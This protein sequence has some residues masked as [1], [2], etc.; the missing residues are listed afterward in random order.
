[1]PTTSFTA[2]TTHATTQVNTT[3][4]G[5]QYGEQ[6]VTLSN[7]SSVIFY[8]SGNQVLARTIGSNGAPS[9]SEIVIA[10][11][12]NGGFD[13]QI[14]ATVLTNG[15]IAVAYCRNNGA[16]TDIVYVIRDSNMNFISSGV[17]TTGV[18]TL[19][20]D[21]AATAGGGFVIAYEKVFS[22]TDHDIAFRRFD[23]AGTSTDPA[24]GVVFDGSGFYDE[25]PSVAVLNDGKIV[26]GY[27]R[28]DTVSGNTGAWQMVANADATQFLAPAQFDGFGTYNTRADV[29]ALSGGG[30]AINY[31]DNG[32]GNQDIT[33]AIFNSSGVFQSYQH[34]GQ[35]TGL[36]YDPTSARSA[37]GLVLVASLDGSGTT[38]SSGAL[39]AADGTLLAANL[40]LVA[41]F[42]Y[43]AAVSWID[44]SHI[45]IASNV[46]ATNPANDGSGNGIAVTDIEIRRIIDGDATSET[47]VAP[48]DGLLNTIHGNGGDDILT[49]NGA[50]NFV[51]G[52]AGNDT[53]FAGLG[54]PETLDGGTG[55][56]TLDTTSWAFD[57]TVNLTTG[58]T[59]YSGELFT[60][61]ENLT[62]GA[63]NDTLTGTSGVNII[64]GGSGN[65]VIDGLGG[66]D[67]VHGDDGN[68]V[69]TSHGT[70]ESIFGDAGDDT[71]FA[72]LGTPET[73]DGGIGIDTL[74]T[75]SFAGNYVVN[76][77]TGATNYSG[78]SFTNFENL[79]SGAGNDTLTGTTAANIIH[80]GDGNDTISGGGGTDTVFGDAGDDVIIVAPGDGLDNADGGAG[81][82]TLDYSGTSGPINFNMVSG[83]LN[84][85]GFSVSSTNFENFIGSDGNDIVTATAGNNQIT[86]GL[87]DDILDG[88]AGDDILSGGTGS[89]QYFGRAGNDIYI[90]TATTTA[91]AVSNTLFEL[92]GE[93]TDEVR[94]TLSVFSL[95]WFGA[96]SLDN[97]TATDN[98]NHGA[99]I[100]NAFDNVI[101]GGTGVDE[102]FGRGGNDTLIGGTGS[103]N[104]LFGQA[105]ND[106]YVIQAA[107]DSVIEFVGEG[108]DT[109]QTALGSFVL[110]DNVEN[111]TYTG[112]GSFVGI[113]ST[114]NNTITGGVLADDLSGL[115]GND[116]LI[117]GS[118]NDQLQGGSG[119]DQFRYNGGESGLDRVLD[120][121]SGSDKIA[122]SG[123]GFVH[124]GTIDFVQ[125]GAPAPTSTN[126]TFLYN[127]N[128]GIVS[129]DADGTGA[130]AAVQLAQLNAG[131][132]LAAAD[133]I[134]F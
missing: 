59:N 104:A 45:R 97:L 14:S 124:T 79:T 22:T 47:I 134:F 1:M 49:S 108:I 129:Y 43:D 69:L 58:L 75:T 84:F 96:S 37:F 17:A 16:S 130:G 30:Y 64:N 61:F 46:L 39:L 70:N 52:D 110:R 87:G 11:N 122:L 82:D 115:G 20:P 24:S 125:N 88:G 44:G 10:N 103:A 101:T 4:A 128:N 25:F 132:T 112:V 133:F 72:G 38:H 111:L 54:I 28:L 56:D 126:S 27:D 85:S 105:G 31:A 95:E 3:T 21:I 50:N 91:E 109:V 119:A 51:Y 89:N 131:L 36:E 120:F 123:S 127:V 53:I 60:N 63:G 118:G 76:L 67:T 114:D 106:V 5:E 116:I 98:A 23:S 6:I 34:A 117:G 66:G 9:G 42:S 99:L 8:G 29:I 102:I 78:E 40:S 74:D 26:I 77:T 62:S 81:V 33:S 57:Y 32:W 71:I 93:G 15:N 7:G 83:V 35:G 2:T 13:H 121:V 86:T 19:H 100:G 68:D 73:L 113:G 92:S 48:S 55:I 90:V 41:P 94:A 107:G 80:G 65:D 18:A 12:Y